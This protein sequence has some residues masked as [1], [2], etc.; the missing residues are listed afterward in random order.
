M[1]VTRRSAIMLLLSVSTCIATLGKSTYAMSHPFA[2][3]AWMEEFLPTAENVVRKNSTGSCNEWV[4]LCIDDGTRPFTCSGPQGSMQIHSVG[5]YERESGNLS[6][7]ELESRF[8]DALGNMTS[9]VPFMDLH[10]AFYTKDLDHYIRAFKTANV[11]T[12]ASTFTQGHTYYSIAVQVDGSLRAGAGSMLVLLLVG[13]T[14]TLLE[15]SHRNHR[16][17]HHAIPLVAAKSLSRAT[18]KLAGVKRDASATAPPALSMLHVSFPSTNVTRDSRYFEGVLGGTKVEHSVDANGTETYVGTLFS[19]D[20]HEL[21]WAHSEAPESG[22]WRVADWEAYS[23]SLHAEC[24]RSPNYDNQGFD[25]LAD[26]HVGAH[27]TPG[28]TVLDG[29]IERQIAAGLPYRAFVGPSGNPTF[30]YLYGP[31]GWG[32]Q[33]TGYCNDADKCGSNL[34]FYNMCTQGIRGQCSRDLP[35]PS[36]DYGA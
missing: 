4:K 13:D 11:P 29:Y 35:S 26:N 6:L 17:H 14:S 33:I 3:K 34:N 10:A 30:L 15:P 9:Y 18:T 8:T 7:A 20:A 32:Y 27:G 16:I 25:R 28:G 21:R 2:Y 36:Y 19:G 1:S 24:M 5:A 22:A 23:S 12:F 31:N